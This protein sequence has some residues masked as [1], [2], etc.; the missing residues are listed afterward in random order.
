MGIGGSAL[1]NIA[2][3]TVLNH[4]FYNILSDKDKNGFPRVFV[5]DNIDPD[6]FSGRIA[7]VKPEETL[8][9]FITKSGTTVE[10]MSQ[11][12][13]VVK[14]LHDRLGNDYREH[15]IATTD[16]EKGTLRNIQGVKVLSPSR[17]PEGLEGGILH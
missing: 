17:S 7:F 2:T 5:L 13:I 12:L 15:I 10:T 3:H 8:F 4:P 16:S 6:R 9:N 11:F 14:L 1:G